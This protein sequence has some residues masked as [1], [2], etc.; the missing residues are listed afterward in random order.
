LLRNAIIAS[1]PC[2]QFLFHTLTPLTS[3]TVP[4]Y[5]ESRSVLNDLF[6]DSRILELVAESFVEALVWLLIDY[7]RK[8]RN[9]DKKEKRNDGVN[10]DVVVAIDTSS[11]GEVGVKTSVAKPEEEGAASFGRSRSRL[12]TLCSL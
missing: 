2:N 1:S 4:M 3:L 12:Q 5:T 8:H 9:D 7:A 6:E 11:T 10:A